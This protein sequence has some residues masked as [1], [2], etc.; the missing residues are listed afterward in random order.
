MG[1]PGF[2]NRRLYIE[3]YFLTFLDYQKSM[4]RKGKD[5]YYDQYSEIRNFLIAILV[6]EMKP[7]VGVKM[8]LHAE[9]NKSNN[10]IR[11]FRLI[12]ILMRGKSQ[13]FDLCIDLHKFHVFGRDHDGRYKASNEAELKVS[14]SWWNI[15]NSIIW[16]IGLSVLKCKEQTRQYLHR[17]CFTTEKFR[18][19]T[20]IEMKSVVMGE[21]WGW[22]WVSRK[23]ILGFLPKFRTIRALMQAR[24]TMIFQL[25]TRLQ[26]LCF[27]LKIWWRTSK[28]YLQRINS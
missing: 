27:Q 13:W 4:A 19:E 14:I 16:N 17:E 9:I 24:K 7:V 2:E 5:S 15:I 21:K 25:N 26:V 28:G 22:V 23:I 6:E 1:K 20:L 11:N 18:I 8:T 12:K 10:I 3:K